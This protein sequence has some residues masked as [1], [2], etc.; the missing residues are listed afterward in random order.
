MLKGKFVSVILGTF[1]SAVLTLS[2]LPNSYAKMEVKGTISQDTIWKMIVQ[3]L[4]CKMCFPEVLSM[5]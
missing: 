2:L 5:S 1:L 4:F 3:V